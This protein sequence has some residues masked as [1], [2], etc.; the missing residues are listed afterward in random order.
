M[1]V[2]GR[3]GSVGGRAAWRCRCDC[4][5]EVLVRADKL[6]GGRRVSCG[7][8]ECRYVRESWPYRREWKSWWAMKG[9]CAATSGKWFCNYGSRGIAVCERW[10]E[11]ANFLVDMGV[12]PSP[13]HTIER[14]DNDRG[15]EPGNCRWATIKEQNRNRRDTVY[16]C[17]D[18]GDEFSLADFCEYFFIDRALVYGRIKNGWPLERVL[19]DR[20]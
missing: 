14:V 9:R 12:K 8:L 1:T 18:E 2:V 15:Y 4:G 11:F 10:R 3:E 16:V 20:I 7:R 6:R 17:D 13:L 5:C 19:R